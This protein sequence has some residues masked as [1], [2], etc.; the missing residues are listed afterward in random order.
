MSWKFTEDG[1]PVIIY[2][3]NISSITIQSSEDYTT[4]QI[5]IRISAYCNIF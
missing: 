5:K 2:N 4:K 3:N 1:I